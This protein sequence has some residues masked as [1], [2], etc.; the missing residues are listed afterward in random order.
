M[1]FYCNY[2]YIINFISVL[3]IPLASARLYIHLNYYI[4]LPTT[5]NHHSLETTHAYCRNLIN[6]S[7]IQCYTK[8][9]FL[10]NIWGQYSQLFC[11]RLATTILKSKVSSKYQIHNK[12]VVT[13]AVLLLLGLQSLNKYYCIKLRINRLGRM[14]TVSD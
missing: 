13:T 10:K 6:Y 11:N 2:L 4:T 3:L 9:C 12:A 8:I 14:V 7:T 5:I 1:R